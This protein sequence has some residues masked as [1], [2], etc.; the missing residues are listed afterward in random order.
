MGGGGDKKVEREER[1]TVDICF[2]STFSSFLFLLFLSRTKNFHF[3]AL[4]LLANQGSSSFKALASL[5]IVSPGR[6]LLLSHNPD[7]H[8][9]HIFHTMFVRRFTA[10]CL[11]SSPVF[12]LPSSIG[13][14]SQ[15]PPSS[16]F[17]RRMS[18]IPSPETSNAGDQN[19]NEWPIDIRKTPFGCLLNDPN[20]PLPKVEKLVDVIMNLTVTEMIE[21]TDLISKRMGVD[22]NQMSSF[23]PP[24]VY[25]AAP[26]AGAAS[27]PAPATAT[28]PDAA[29]AAPPVPE[30]T[31]FKVV[32]SALKEGSSVKLATIKIVKEIK[33]LQLPEVYP[34][35]YSVC[36]CS[37]RHQKT[38][39]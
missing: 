23:G 13:R 16:L 35:F 21:F 14:P 32:V 8:I 26:P 28:A 2:L 34:F 39:F 3:S 27:A 12:K 5:R 18:E 6:P 1:Q 37:L 25:A 19:P 7:H 4:S 33:N 24:V 36:L 10:S 31:S 17:C 30:K 29:A 15:L 9:H 38:S 20:K 11:R 22:P